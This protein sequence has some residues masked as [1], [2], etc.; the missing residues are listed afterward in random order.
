MAINRIQFQSGMSVTE[1]LRSYG[2]EEQCSAAVKA[3]R[4]TAGFKCPRCG[5]AAHCEIRRQGRSLFQ[6]NACRHQASL[7][8]GT[9]FASTKLPLTKWF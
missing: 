4:W 2:T 5:A 7:I 3:A 1:F 8:A 9:M 6:C